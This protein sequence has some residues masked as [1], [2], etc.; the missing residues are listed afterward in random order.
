VTGSDTAQKLKAITDLGLVDN[1][2][3]NLLANKVPMGS[4]VLNAIK[5]SSGRE[6]SNLIAELLADPEKLKAALEIK[7]AAKPN[8]FAGISKIHP[9]A[10]PAA[11]RLLT[12]Q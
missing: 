5:E 2:F 4:G 12:Q 9:L 8:K 3:I 10:I 7:R 1:K 11:S 6:R